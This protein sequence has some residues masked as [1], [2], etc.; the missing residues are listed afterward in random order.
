MQ[1]ES[2][3]SEQSLK[4]VAKFEKNFLWFVNLLLL[5]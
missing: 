4:S 1:L 5:V 2:H 3:F